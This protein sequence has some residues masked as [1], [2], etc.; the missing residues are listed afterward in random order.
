MKCYGITDRGILR[1]SNQDSYVI[2]YNEV[3]DVFAMVCDGIGGG[4]GGD[5]ASHLAVRHFSEAFA[6]N[7]GFDNA[8]EVQ[9][10]VR[11][12]ITKCNRRI[13]ETGKLTEAL[14][15]M[16]TT[17]S[18]VLICKC[19]RF[20]IN[21]G[22]SR[23]Y[24]YLKDGTFKQLT[25]D[26]TLVQDM[27]MHGE[28]SVDEAENYPKKNV[29]TNALGVW[30]SVRS[31]IDLHN[32]A[33]SGLLICSDGLHGYVEEEKIASIVLD[34]EIDPC[35]RVRKLLQAALEAGGYDNV[36]AILI[37]LEGDKTYEQ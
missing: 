32:E 3:G 14:R 34:E 17:L 22:D 36:T 2:A 1:K 13:Y 7:K 19:G 12:E 29:L 37:D 30:S 25:T 33:M 31:D 9:Y 20:V 4:N 8:E 16:G 28:L 5:V 26:H 27:I 6:K 11:K 15:G 24:A 18:G 23:V 21:I 10:F 35:L